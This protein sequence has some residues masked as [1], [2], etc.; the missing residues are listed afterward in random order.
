MQTKIRFLKLEITDLQEKQELLDA[1]ARVLDHGRI[2]LGPEVETL[3]SRIAQYTGRKFA[4]GVNSGTDALFI[5]LRALG[6]GPGHEVITTPLSWIA[7]ANAI[8]MTGATPVF[9]DI[10]PDLNMDP[11]SLSAL[12]TENTRGIMPVHYTGRICDME[13]LLEVAQ[14]HDLFLIEDAAQAFGARYQD[15]P[16]GAFGDVACFSMNPMKVLAAV[17]EAGMI[18]TDDEELYD[19]IQILRYNGTVNKETCIL[20]A[21]NGRLDTLQAAVLLKRLDRLQVLI[22]RRREI[23][24]WYNRHLSSLVTVPPL[25]DRYDVFYTYTIQA[26]HRDQ[27]KNYLEQQGIETKIQHPILMPEQPAYQNWTDGRFENARKLQERILC[28]PAHEKLT[29]AE[30]EYVVET[31]RSFYERKK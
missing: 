15:K 16:A 11:G 26:D 13:P 30:M 3:E 6:I 1:M 23:A 14:A 8:A 19:R 20:P 27:L 17:G 24:A 5:A 9:A 12:I 25:D 7:T 4:I 22:E 29:Q 18:V 2:V 21:L 28:L 31:I 10:G